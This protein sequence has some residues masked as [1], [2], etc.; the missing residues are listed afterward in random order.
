MICFLLF[1]WCLFPLQLSSCH[2]WFLAHPPCFLAVSPC[3]DSVSPPCQC[4]MCLHCLSPCQPSSVCLHPPVPSS[5][6]CLTAFL[7]C[8]GFS[9]CPLCEGGLHTWSL[10]GNYCQTRVWALGG[11]RHLQRA[12]SRTQ[13]TCVLVVKRITGR[14]DAFLLPRLLV[15]FEPPWDNG[16]LASGSHSRTCLWVASLSEDSPVCLWCL[17]LLLDL[18]QPFHPKRQNANLFVYF[19]P[20]SERCSPKTQSLIIGGKVTDWSPMSCVCYTLVSIL[21]MWFL[22]LLPIILWC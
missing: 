20:W 16:R 17:S 6:W 9:G 1:S 3:P 10:R 21:Q 18:Y 13:Q 8:G 12:H 22:L 7:R 5:V 19:L 11:L 15:A 2:R 14:N 4:I